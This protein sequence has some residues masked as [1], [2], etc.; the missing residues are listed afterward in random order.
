MNEILQGVLWETLLPILASLVIAL[1]GWAA[2]RAAQWLRA[3]ADMIGIERLEAATQAL[4]NAAELAAKETAQVAVNAIKA[5]AADGRLTGEEARAALTAARDR[6]WELLAPEIRQIL[7]GLFGSEQA[8]KLNA[9][10]PAIEAAVH[11]LKAGT[12]T[13]GDAPVKLDHEA[14][15]TAAALARARLGLQ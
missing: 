1:I 3:K 9:V 12:A 6:A 13:P 4:I 8:A 2:G 14:R 5:S 15:I 7:I 11:D 10:T